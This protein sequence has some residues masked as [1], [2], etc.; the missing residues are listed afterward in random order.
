MST[1]DGEVRRRIVVG[2][3]GSES[4]IYALQ[5]AQRL[6]PALDA[7]IDAIMT[8]EYPVSLG[9][10]MGLTE[11]SPADDAPQLLATALKAAF[12][13][14]EPAGIRSL[15]CEGHPAKTLLWASR[16]AEML[17]VGSRGHGGFAGL[18]IGAT[19]AY[20]A[21]HATCAVLVVH[22]KPERV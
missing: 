11:W 22:D 6:G 20:C 21:A 17:V 5:W 15:I 8:W 10:S 18:L 4:S 2:V 14:D 19:S 9:L 1:G 13:E 7:E 12:G 16:D 3:D